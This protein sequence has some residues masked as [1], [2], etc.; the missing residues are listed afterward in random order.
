VKIALQTLFLFAALCAA[1]FL[2]SMGF[3]LYALFAFA[4]AIWM[5]VSLYKTNIRIQKEVALFAEMICYRDFSGKLSEK[6]APREIRN[7]RRH[8]NQIIDAIKQLH[9]EKE[10]HHQYLQKVLEVVDTGII[11][12]NLQ[13]GEVLWMNDAAKDTLRIPFLTTIRSLEKRNRPFFDDMARIKSGT[14]AVINLSI[15]GSAIKIMVSKSLFQIDHQPYCL[16]AMQN[17][18]DALNENEVK[19]WQKLLSVMTHEIMNSVA[20]IASLADTLQRR[21]EELPKDIENEA[22]ED[23]R[24]GLE[25][26]GRRSNGLLRFAVTY[27]NLNKIGE[28]VLETVSI[29]PFFEHLRKL[30]MPTMEQK[31]ID[32]T[33]SLRDPNLSLQADLNLL[34]QVLINLITNAM[35]AVTEKEKKRIELSASQGND[36]KIRMKV[37]DNGQGIPPQTMEHIFMPFFSGRPGGSGIGLNLCR[38]IMLMHKGAIHVKSE[39]GRGSV[40]TLQF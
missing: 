23:L 28:P 12:Y 17:V 20:P 4:A 24:V 5:V 25:T 31:G 26:I 8:F 11:S 14:P 1:A 7:I 40:F 21:L 19:A 22:M 9:R 16:I 39:V 35:E 37:S 36:H 15:E 13:S 32:F 2:L 3:Y 10:I 18:S 27:R 30:L 29:A 38:Q 34:E 6:Q 33:L